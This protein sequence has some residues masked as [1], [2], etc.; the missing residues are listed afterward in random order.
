LASK[1]PETKL[2]IDEKSNYS[3]LW[4]GTHP[5]LP[6]YDI[7]SSRPLSELVSEN[8]TLL[9]TEV[10]RKYGDK[11]PF[12]FKVLSI[13]K[14]LSIQAHPNKK[15]AQQLH[16]RD[17]KNYP[18]DNHKPEMTIALTPFEGLCGFRPL[19]QIS[20]FLDEIKPLRKAV[21]EDAAKAY[22]EGIKPAGKSIEDDNAN[23]KALQKAFGALMKADKETI[24]SSIAD[25]VSLAKDSPDSFPE[26]GQAE[27]ITRLSEQY[28]GD[29]GILVQLFLNHLVLKPGEALFL[30]ADDIHAYL[31]GDVI[32]CMAAS[33]N[34]V[35]AGLTPKFK[36]VDTLVDM[37]TYR[38]APIEEQKL[39]P[40][41]YPYVT[42]NKTAF[43]SNSLVKLYD[44]PIEEFSV[45]RTL[46]NKDG[47]KATFERIAGPSII[48]CTQGQGTIAIGEIS[49]KIDQGAIYFVGA[50]AATTLLA[51][52]ATDDA[53]FETF[54]AFCE[55]SDEIN[56]K[57]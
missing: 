44:P 56:G 43:E 35:R 29:I 27:L 31:Q 30:Q 17:S 6:S 9:S 33:D 32:E 50:G 51:E 54:R 20:K 34:V 10:A 41:N 13:Q 55:V 26:K 18:D 53:P 48:L 38:T 11:L 25:L 15:L 14:A 42:L 4:M 5:K 46:L 40:A 23:K 8:A 49:E 2:S 36:D 28:P 21:G 37:L 16:Q 1:T 22:Q 47:A 45:L 57:L 52:G 24:E 19:D 7:K 12:L 39:E 3:E